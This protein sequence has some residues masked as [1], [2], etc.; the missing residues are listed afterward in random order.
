MKIEEFILTGLLSVYEYCVL[1]AVKWIP[2]LYKQRQLPYRRQSG[3]IDFHLLILFVSLF[4]SR[5]FLPKYNGTHAHLARK[6]KTAEMKPTLTVHCLPCA[7]ELFFS[8]DEIQWIHLLILIS[9]N[10]SISDFL[11]LCRSFLPVLFNTRG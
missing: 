7:S 8:C 4:C 2:I 10:R 11:L 5:F 9:I 6:K 3:F 1:C